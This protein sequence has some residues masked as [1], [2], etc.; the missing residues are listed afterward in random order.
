MEKS[1]NSEVILRWGSI[2][3]TI[4]FYSIGV[5]RTNAKLESEVENFKSQISTLD[6]KFE[7]LEVN[8][9]DKY[10]VD[11]ILNKLDKIDSKLDRI[12]ETR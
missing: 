7:K 8:K 5:V 11:I 6:T 10:I 3:L 4:I 9:A 2:I 1:K 12:Q